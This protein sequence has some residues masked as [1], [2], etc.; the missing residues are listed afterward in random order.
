MNTL[1]S[2]LKKG[3]VA[4]IRT[5]TL[6]GLVGLAE[7]PHTVDRIYAIKQRNPLKPVIVLLADI[8]DLK[9]FG[10]D[11]NIDLE[12]IVNLYWPG[13]VSIVIETSDTVDLHHIHKG[14]G[15]V[16]FRIPD[17]EIL[18]ELLRKT[19]PLVAPSANPEGQEPAKNIKEAMSYFGDLV[20][21]YHDGGECLDVK[22]SKIIKI[23]SADDSVDIIRE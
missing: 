21:F 15:G 6:Y 5:D 11:I 3:G 14:T 22:H 7:N 10:I 18:R 8:I 9:R 23:N 20:D 4:V 19:G 13:P 1:I 16:A 17:N 2:I 12:S